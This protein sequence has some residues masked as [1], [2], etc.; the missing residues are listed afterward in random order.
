M[1]CG[2]TTVAHDRLTGLLATVDG[3]K[4]AAAP[5]SPTEAKALGAEAR[6]I[7]SSEHEQAERIAAAEATA[8]QKAAA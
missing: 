1:S 4:F 3:I 6:A 2:T 8:S 7:V 5:V